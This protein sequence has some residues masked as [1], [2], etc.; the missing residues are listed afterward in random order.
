MLILGLNAFHGDASAALLEDGQLTAAVEEERF[1]R[2]KHWA[3]FPAIA[4]QWCL[5]GADQ[6]EL[7]HV[8][9][10]RDPKAHLARKLLRMALRPGDWG[11]LASRTQNTIKV[12]RLASALADA[13]VVRPDTVR[14][15]H[16][17]HHHAH[18]ASAFFCSPFE[19]AA[20][21]S[22]DGFGD[23][24]SVM[25]AAGRG[26][27][28]DVQGAT[29]FP[30]SLGLFY[31]A[32]TQFLGFPKYGDEYKMM[33]MSAYGE[34]RFLSQMRQV[35][36]IKDDQVRLNL[37]Y[38]IHH[39][40]GVEMTWDNCEPTLGRV[41]SH[42]MCEV[43]GIPREYRAEL[44]QQHYD[45]AASVQARLEEC[46]F[47]LLNA[48]YARTKQR[49]VCLAGGVALNCVANGKIFERTPFR[50][51]YVQAAS[52]DA[53]TS[54]GA[55][56]YVWHQV[57]GKPREYVM[58][59]VYY[60]P[61]YTETE[62]KQALDGA[63]VC[64]QRLSED[65]LVEQTARE[66]AD[67]RVVGWF[68]GRMEFGP[69]ALGSR[70]ILAD[71]RSRDMKDILNQ[72]IK[73][74]E[75]FRPFCPSVIAEA[76]GDFF[77]NDYPSPFMVQAYRIKPSQRER[78]PA[79]THED[80]TGRLQTVEQ[81][82]NPLYWSLLKRFGEITGVPILINTSFNENEPI[83]NTPAQALDCFLRTHMDTLVIGPF[84]M[85]KPE[86]ADSSERQR[87]VARV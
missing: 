84:L 45:I 61:G 80:G 41:Y 67:G 69:R 9:I 37:D 10:S 34:P 33:G 85:R 29:H 27:H 49:A 32:F 47:E 73:H 71:P 7:A 22:I 52:H 24:S 40:E 11:K 53:G 54:I 43:F 16:V 86:N 42:K 87:A 17:E 28:F 72:R 36:R 21:V 12:A 65:A 76:T 62:I 39:T 79:V 55:A 2:I 59:H 56:Q 15:H 70:S 25:W 19:E 8:A 4:A 63:E 18:L 57:L 46:Y 31:T 78:I 5:R 50:D 68:Q 23:F 81:Y 38:F 30:H 75:H 82:V 64:Y 26:H 48:V 1:N 83:V 35:V 14:V 66:I 60:G 13:G 51:V 3:G 58:K 6:A 20:V 74:R 44:L 77:E